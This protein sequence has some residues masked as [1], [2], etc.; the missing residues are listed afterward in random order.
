MGEGRLRG[1]GVR[2]DKRGYG[3][4]ELSEIE[5]VTKWLYTDE[6]GLY[7]I[8]HAKQLPVLAREHPEFGQFREV[9]FLFKLSMVPM[10]TTCRVVAVK[11]WREQDVRVYWSFQGMPMSNGMVFVF[12]KAFDRRDMLSIQSRKAHSPAAPSTY[13]TKAPQQQAAGAFGFFSI[14]G[15]SM[16]APPTS[17]TGGGVTEEDVIHCTS[18]PLFDH[19]LT[20]EASEALMSTLTV[21]YLRIPLLLAF[22]A[23]K[24]RVD[25]LHHHQLQRLFSCALFEPS[26]WTRSDDYDPL[27]SVPAIGGRLGSCY[28][29]LLNEMIHSPASLLVPFL[30]ILQF[31][32][33]L[34]TGSFGTVSSSLLLFLSSMAVRIEGYVRAA[35]QLVERKAV[36]CSPINL[37]QLQGHHAELLHLMASQ[38]LPTLSSY[39]S[40]AASDTP[41]A[42]FLHSH[43]ALL[44]QTQLLQ[45][46]LSAHDAFQ[47]LSTFLGAISFVM[48][49]HSSGVG[50][51]KHSRDEAEMNEDADPTSGLDALLSGGNFL[52]NIASSIS[53]SMESSKVKKAKLAALQA[54]TQLNKP[55]IPETSLFT[56]LQHSRPVITRWL[57]QQS[58]ATI[59]SLLNSIVRYVHGQEAL[60]PR[61]PKAAAHAG[62][63]V[64]G[65][66]VGRYLSP[67]G[68]VEVDMQT[69]SVYNHN[70]HIH[71]VSDQISRSGDFQLVF[72]SSPHHYSLLHRYE[73]MSE[74]AVF[75][76]PMTLQ[77][78]LPQDWFEQL[79]GMP[80][81]VPKEM[82]ELS[83][84]NYRYG[85]AITTGGEWKC[86]GKDCKR[87]NPGHAE[88]CSQCGTHKPTLSEVEKRGVMYAG[89][90]YTR[91]Y[92]STPL[93]ATE[94]WII[95]LIEEILFETY[96]EKRE[97]FNFS[98]FLPTQPVPA[99]QIRRCCW[100][101]MG[102]RGSSS[103]ATGHARLC[104]AFLFHPHGRTVYRSLIYTSNARLC[105]RSLKPGTKQRWKPWGQFC[106][107]QAGNVDEV[108]PQT[109]T[110]VIHRQSSQGQQ[111]FTPSAL[112]YGLVP[113][114]LLDHFLFW[115]VQ[116][117]EGRG[118]YLVGEP[119]ADAPYS[120]GLKLT[121]DEP[122]ST[123]SEQDKPRQERWDVTIRQVQVDEDGE[124]EEEKGEEGIY[125]VNLLSSTRND[126]LHRLVQILTR[127]E[128]IAHILVWSSSPPSS[129]TLH[130][131]RVELPRLKLSF[132]PRV[133]DYTGE[134]RL[135]SS[136]HAGFF[137]TDYRDEALTA[138]LA[139]CLSLSF[140][141]TT[142]TSCGSSLSTVL[143]IA[144]RCTAAPSPPS[145]WQTASTPSGCRP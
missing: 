118:G 56:A 36:R 26:T 34:D 27:S 21:P 138:L 65:K 114:A 123:A 125:L 32:L 107:Y 82:G 68:T 67:D 142:G 86:A 79:V 51:G 22:F 105:L 48:T 28:G 80:R 49:W 120:F 144:L 35:L 89:V 25:L 102:R 63:S 38:F 53:T 29:L 2:H 50:I 42:V 11:R 62:W 43:I 72:G 98:L 18:L 76:L 37:Q 96:G 24:D 109:D 12:A 110:L 84:A 121:M 73:A 75:G 113:Q 70:H 106:R 44:A 97:S 100:G 58:P 10:R 145:W 139:P 95:D 112:L 115:Q 127:I 66:V 99:L 45:P 46:N 55:A 31:A 85:T 141:R 19:L 74:F 136:D 101:W 69:G 5:S 111:L 7:G 8:S 52:S 88:K 143:C 59:D 64:C 137:L 126:Q 1:C 92:G 128:D 3:G 90:T 61:S 129:P 77:W 9:M 17:S 54:A 130:I 40:Q 117:A 78:W 16:P 41:Q 87:E 15:L 33:D 14:P 134:V 133:D 47:A 119:K 30:M 132:S 135:Y 93:P 71:P 20:L 124:V 140:L 108:V 39:R 6:D 60:S 103:C 131:T 122:D 57:Q 23:N 91:R 81:V 116:G 104:Q 83:D 94:G 4:K 13:I